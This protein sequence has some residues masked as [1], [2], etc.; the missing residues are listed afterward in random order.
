M[1]VIASDRLAIVAADG[2]FSYHDLD[3]T[4]ARVAQG[5]AESNELTGSR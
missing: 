2:V 1:S 4:G 5:R 3:V